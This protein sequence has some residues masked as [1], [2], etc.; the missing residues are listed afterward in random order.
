M[1]QAFPPLIAAGALAAA[2]LFVVTAWRPAVGCMVLAIAIPLTG[3]MARG[4]VVP[5][6]RV[7]EALLLI[8]AAGMLVH[9]LPR[10]R[11]LTF[12]GLDLAVIAFSAGGVLVPW[13]VIKLGG[14]DAS[15]DTWLTIL[16]PI[17][18]LV[19]YAL[20]SRVDLSQGDLRMLINVTLLSSV[21]VALVA[22]AE[23]ANAPVV[24]QVIAAYYPPPARAPGDVST[25]YRPTSLLG[26]FS[27][28]GAFGLFNMI[29]ALALAAARHRGFRSIWLGA[30]MALN[31]AAILATETWAPLLAAP[32]AVLIIV[33]YARHVPWQLGFAPPAFLGAVIA[34]WPSVSA[35]LLEQRGVR[36]SLLPESMQ[37]RVGYWQDFFLPSLLNHQAWFGTGTLIP[38]EVPRPLVEFVDNGYLWMAY[39]AG[40]PGVLLMLLVLGAIALGGWNLRNSLQPWHVALGATCLAM[41]ISVALLEVTSEYLTFTSVSQEFWMLVGL[42]G[43]A[44]TQRHPAAARFVALSAQ[45]PGRLQRRGL[46]VR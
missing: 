33:L 15:I 5:L 34:F 35:R 10:R 27:A 21:I 32:L 24:R 2:G 11:T 26:H 39:R 6:L 16:S 29:L 3:G 22:L 8:V 25:V 42:L 7:N 30:V 17:Q 43:A 12:M 46:P 9:E 19:V 4:S 1:I 36:G 31:V 13:A 44:L 40:V 45:P 38:S 28:V 18:Y 14:A 20:F 41:V 37:V 23:L